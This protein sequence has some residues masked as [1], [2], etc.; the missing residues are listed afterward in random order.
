VSTPQDIFSQPQHLAVPVFQRR[1]VWNAE[2]Q[3]E[4]LW[5]DITRI[6]HKH[7]AGEAAQH[8]LGAVVTQTSST[9]GLGL[10]STHGLI[11]GQQRLTTLQL[12]IDAAAAE[13]ESADLSPLAQQLTNLT[14]NPQAFGAD[15]QDTLKLQH[16]NDDRV[17]F[18]AVMSAEPPI[19]YATLPKSRLVEAHQYFAEQIREW[20][21]DPVSAE[22][23]QALVFALS[24]GLQV[25]VIA[26]DH[27][28]PSQEIFETLNARGTP[29]TAA[30]LIKNYVFQQIV[31]EGGSAEAAF[32]DHWQDLERPFW[33]KE[34]S[35]GRYTME[36]LSL[37]LN[38]W[39]VARTGE[40]V[41][42]RSTFTRFKS[43]FEESGR[44]M[45][46]V[47]LS[48]HR[49]A[50]AFE[51][52]VE[53]S[54]R[55]QGDLDQIPL[56]VYRT[57][58][59]DV[60]AVKPL[61]LRLFDVDA[62]LPNEVAAQALRDVESW[63]MR[64]AL[65]RRP[66]SEYSRVVAGL[67]DDL[68]SVRPEDIATALR[69]SLQRLN[70]PGTYWPGTVE[71]TGELATAPIYTQPKAR[72]RAYL[73]AIEDGI[74][75]YAAGSPKSDSRVR[76][77]S[78]TVEHLLPQRWKAAW[79][80]AGLAEEIERDAHVHRLGNLTLLTQTLNS[81]VSNG[82]W[83]GEKGKRAALKASDTLLMTRQ[84]RD[85]DEW[86][87]AL[88]DARTDRMLTALV[89]TWPAPV[90]HNPE[91]VKRTEDDAM[92]AVG[93]REL[94][95]AGSLPVGTA[96]E[97]REGVGGG[98]T[99]RV[100]SNGRLELNGKQHDSPSG[101]GKAVLGRAVNG[102]NFWRLPDGRRLM[103]VRR[104]HAGIVRKP[105]LY[106]AFWE[107]LLRR[108][109][110]GHPGWSS[111]RGTDASWLSLPYGSSSASYTMFFSNAGQAI[112]LVFESP[113]VEAND[114]AYAA[115]LAHRDALESAFGDELVWEAPGGIKARRIRVYRADGGRVDDVNDREAQFT[116]FLSTMDRFR[117]ATQ[118]VRGLIE[119]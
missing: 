75:G 36:R 30:D 78:L 4:P 22:R 72:V 63:V 115:F 59:A 119:G 49:Q 35:I 106:R 117:A 67:I 40:E 54:R 97:A 70:R 85:E 6:A 105:V 28:E 58:A 62:P 9:G 39:L 57:E 107:E 15:G 77:G 42:T 64:R 51:G 23:A 66:A 112:E 52:W 110:Q 96:L 104:E 1:Y 118:H 109:E 26:L 31:R 8:F 83:E 48:L 80:V 71:L 81:S 95:A 82:P 88:I 61:L 17:A 37:F 53:E 60:E 3:W 45:T 34:V 47:L 103:D 87:E 27:L 94:V 55:S 13:L 86:T 38:H 113:D 21:G 32:R 12:L 5:R 99:A 7:L 69:A 93:L 19:E 92:A 74:R 43:W 102:W 2:A 20:L 10:I 76:R 25:V 100:L 91:P 24:R 114:A 108:L 56:F 90:D 89:D 44:T 116:W 79:P 50:E 11:D 98:H 84:P 16:E 33:T 73:E 46:E 29:L 18:V 65:L 41:S 101:A 111:S 14:H 68:R